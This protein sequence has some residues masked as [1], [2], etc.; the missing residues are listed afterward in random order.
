MR[1]SNKRLCLVCSKH[2]DKNLFNAHHN[3]HVDKFIKKHPTLSYIELYIKK[4]KNA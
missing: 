4:N 1:K 2:V 3:E